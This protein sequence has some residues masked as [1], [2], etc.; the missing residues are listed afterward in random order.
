MMCLMPFPKLLSSGTSGTILQTGHASRSVMD[1][2][3][4]S[5]YK[6]P[7]DL[8]QHTPATTGKF[9]ALL[10]LGRTICTHFD[11]QRLSTGV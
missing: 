9:P 7:N 6:F 5:R 1:T 2:C 3:Y 11:S 10:F 4:T 8:P